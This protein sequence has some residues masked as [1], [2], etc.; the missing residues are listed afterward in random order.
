MKAVKDCKRLYAL[1]LLIQN[2]VFT[3]PSYF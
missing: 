2:Q 3:D 1:F